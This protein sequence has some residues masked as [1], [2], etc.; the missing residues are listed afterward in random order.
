[1]KSKIRANI[2]VSESGCWEWQ[3]SRLPKGYGCISIGGGK[4]GYAHRESYKAFKGDIPDGMLIMHTCDNPCC[5][6]PEHLEVG[7]QFDNMKD[8][9]RK[10]RTKNTF[11][12]NTTR[13]EGNVKAK[14]KASDVIDIYTSTEVTKV[15]AVK[16]GVTTSLVSMIRRGTVWQHVTSTLANTQ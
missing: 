12:S 16:Y 7:T 13:G 2:K 9:S 6:N 8:A 5:C 10:G 4:R 14:L 3:R 11:N 1:M 15:L